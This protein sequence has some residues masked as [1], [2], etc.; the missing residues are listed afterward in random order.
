M[1]LRELARKRGI[2]LPETRPVKRTTTIA[3]ALDAGYLEPFKVMIM[4]MIKSGTMLD[5]PIS[6]YSD[7]DKVF[8]DPVIKDL[9]D[10]PRLIEGDLREKLYALARDNVKRPERSGWNRGTFLKWAVF[11]EQGTEQLLFLDVDMLCLKPLEPLLD[12]QAGETFLCCPQFQ[13]S[14]RKDDDRIRRSSEIFST[15]EE[16]L[17]GRYRGAH[18]QRVNSGMMLLRG[19][20]ISSDFGKEIISFARERMALHEQGH[21]SDYFRNSAERVMLPVSFNFQEGFLDRLSPDQI[22]EVVR[23]ISILHFAGRVKPWTHKPSVNDRSSLSIWHHYRAAAS[24]VG[25]V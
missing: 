10:K 24:A 15:L 22:E 2:D 17:E 5:C 4:S 7:D 20:F 25:I 1:S 23:R 18:K 19:R 11:E 13:A 16:M 9:V 6:I 21:L 12:T 3:F 14:I 8:L